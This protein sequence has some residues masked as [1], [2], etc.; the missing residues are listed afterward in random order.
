MRIAGYTALALAG[1][2]GAAQ[3][4]LA[5]NVIEVEPNDTLA[6]AQNIDAFFSLDADPD[7]ANATTI[8]HATV[9]A[10]PGNGTF[11][12][13]RFTVATAG[14]MGV[15]DIDYAMPGFDAYLHLFNSAGVLLRQ[16]DD[17]DISLGAGGSIHPYDS[18]MSHTFA[19][20]GQYLIRVGNFPSGTPQNGGLG[21][22]L[23]VSIQN[24]SL[25]GAVP[26]PATWA[27]MIG[28]FGLAGATLRARRR[29]GARL[30][31]A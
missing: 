22:E 21:Y 16:S 25:A 14:S 15:F 12:W 20:A 30:A 31:A 6:T 23:Q 17:A 9:T 11:D 24:H 5:A 2:I 18:F 19:S 26:E 7:I 4:A 13:Y 8:P 28:G 3:P 29:N 1:A 10:G 27:M